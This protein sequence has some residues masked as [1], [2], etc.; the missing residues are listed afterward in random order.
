MVA[1]FLRPGDVTQLAGANVTS[2]PAF[3]FMI[4]LEECRKY[5]GDRLTDEQLVIARDSLYGIVGT[6]L[7]VYFDGQKGLLAEGT[8]DLPI[9][10]K[11]DPMGV[12]I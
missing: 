7:D 12:R 9:R 6:L 5:V 2:S 10:R 1:F 11:H 8:S 3:A 4:S